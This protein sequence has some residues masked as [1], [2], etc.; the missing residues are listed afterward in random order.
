MVGSGDREGGNRMCKGMFLSSGAEGV[1]KT[2]PAELL[3]GQKGP[4]P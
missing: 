3:S 1:K 4:E 2:K